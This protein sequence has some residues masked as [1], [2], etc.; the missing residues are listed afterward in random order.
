MK[1]IILK[2]ME[3]KNFKGIK[4]LTIDFGKDTTISGDN[5]TGKTTIFDAFSWLLFGKNS[6][7]RSKFDIQTLDK[8]G[9]I[10]H[11]IECNVTVILEVNGCEKTLSRTLSEN[12]VK[13]RGQEKAELKGTPT[14]YEVD[15]IPL[16]QKDY[17]IEI[18]N[19]INEDLFK[20]VTNPFFFTSLNWQEQ[21]KILLDIIGDID[22]E[23]VIA[24]NSSLSPLR[25]KVKDDIDKFITKTKATI[26]K[27]KD[28][29]KSLP[30]RID[31]CNNSL[32]DI[33]I[34][35]LESEKKN[36]QKQIEKIDLQLQD[37]SKAG[38]AKFKLQEELF[39]LKNKRTNLISQASNKT[40]IREIEDKIFET[41]HLV[42]KHSMDKE[43]VECKIKKIDIAVDETKL[44]ITSNTS[45]QEKLRN[46]WLKT[47]SEQFI[48]DESQ[49]VCPNCGR[50]YEEGKI[51]EIKES[52]QEK[53]SITKEKKL[54]DITKKGKELGAKILAKKDSLK[55]YEVMRCELK[56]ELDDL[57]NKIKSDSLRIDELVKQKENLST[58][59][60]VVPGLVELEDKIA[61]LQLEIDNFKLD[62]KLELKAKKRTLELNLEDIHKKFA[63]LETNKNLLI[64]IE[65]LKNEEKDLNIKIASLERDLYLGEEF[66]RTKVGLLEDNINKK[67]NGVTFKLFNNL[68]NGGLEDCCE[69]LI[70][71]VPFRD[72]N[73]AGKINAGLSIINTLC[74]H[75]NISAPVFIDNRESI[76]RI[77]NFNGQIV[78]L[79][80]TDDEKLTVSEDFCSKEDEEYLEKKLQEIRDKINP[81]S[82]GYIVDDLFPEAEKI[83]TQIGEPGR[84][85][86]NKTYIYKYKN[87]FFAV[88]WEEPSTELQDGQ[89]TYLNIYRVN[90]KEKRVRVF[91]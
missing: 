32:V 18:N 90:P 72:A 28:K 11:G 31:E 15:G 67:F 79:K 3:I 45:E 46:E 61:A 66:V 48:F 64:R 21:R 63:L 55:H 53:F 27:L 88:S 70:N 52:A 41:K 37:S 91:E 74:E 14:V 71:G 47:N 58:T 84:W 17:Q 35:S 40:A 60:T 73:T 54:D 78:N 49:G 38:E 80:V 33:D 36:I 42:T 25:D 34:E 4:S 1:K 44:E 65:E 69:A 68:K 83:D 29:V 75:Y 85:S 57:I 2:R 7:G 20:M 86:Y 19:L 26:T 23:N 22:N 16:K 5:G 8:T 9:K 62:N 59:E 82:K 77:T 81:Y 10:I 12:W 76:N 24:Y 50:P 6:E 87:M 43:D 13:R 89:E 39:D 30:Y 56:N 51:Q